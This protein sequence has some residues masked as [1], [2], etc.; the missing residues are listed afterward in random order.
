MVYFIKCI[1]TIFKL[2]P[3]F[4]FNFSRFSIYTNIKALFS[5]EETIERF[6]C[7]QRINELT[8]IFSLTVRI[9][10]TAYSP[11]IQGLL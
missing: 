3:A 9:S 2:V 6:K 11:S 10:I 8:E 1:G 5:Y 7:N 4:S